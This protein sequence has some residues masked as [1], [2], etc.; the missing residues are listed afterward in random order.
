MFTIVLLITSQIGFAQFAG[1]ENYVNPEL[2]TD[3][4]ETNN[5]IWFSSKGGV[6]KI[7]KTTLQ[8]TTYDR[9]NSNL[10]INI[11][12][13][14]AKDS[15]DG[16]WIGTYNQAIAKF[17]GTTWTN[18][19]FTH[20]FAPTVI[21][22]KTYCMEIDNQDNVWV[23]TS[24]GLLRFDGT[25]WQVFNS[26][27]AG[28]MLHDV[29]ALDLDSQGNLY[30][31]SF[32]VYKYDG[33]TF[34]NLTDTTSLYLNG[35]A[36]LFFDANDNFWVSDKSGTIGKF[37][38]TTWT[39][40]SSFNGQ[41]P[42]T[43]IYT[44]GE[45]P[46]GEMYF[47]AEDSGKYILQNGVWTPQNIANNIPLDEGNLTTYF[48]D[49]QGDK[50]LANGGNLIKNDGQ[51]ITSLNLKAVE[52]QENNI[53]DVAIFNNTKYFVSSKTITTFDGTTWG[54][55]EFPDSL[56]GNSFTLRQM[57]I[58]DMNNIWIASSVKGI[59]HWNG[60]IW[61]L[62]NQNSS[63]V[64]TSYIHKIAYDAVSQILWC[65]S[66]NGLVKFDGTTWTTYDQTNSPFSGN[67]L[68]KT[69][70]V[71]Y[72]GV[73]Y[74]SAH[75]S[76]F[77]I[78]SFDGTTWQNLT[79][80][81]AGVI[82]PQSSIVSIHFDKNNT[83]W[84][85][86][87]LNGVY[88][89]DGTVWKNWNKTLW[90]LP[91]NNIM[92]ITSDDNGDIYVGTSSGAATFDGTIW[93]GWTLQNSG[94]SYKQIVDIEI[95]DNDKLW[96]GTN[97]GVSRFQLN[98][99]TTTPVITQNQALKIYPNPIIDKAIVQFTTTS[100][101]DNIQVQIISLDG[102]IIQ[103]RII[104]GNRPKGE[105]RIEIAKNNMTS[106]L[107]YLKVIWNDERGVEVILVR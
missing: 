26:Q 103:N 20:L 101:T 38:G 8:T 65:A 39:E 95:D 76:A 60:T 96:L 54:A 1:W 42:S 86:S 106:G 77:E 62:Y 92:T 23:G 68:F 35:R 32:R 75:S 2:L 94:I 56:F 24:R 43:D 4:V 6:I 69:I 46:N 104:N 98:S 48:Y 34:E 25:N 89:Y 79:V 88:K 105:Q 53:K 74:L 19:D 47:T 28:N 64:L 63:A 107:Y 3:Y 102:K 5:E 22:I 17:D 61:T 57:E 81:A 45:T 41:I 37:D 78:W 58:V 29:W 50:W 70:E 9:A 93:T 44:L 14:I 84:A 82:V 90:D 91:N 85:G 15:N 21:R 12:D 36:E 73:L 11:V 27:N 40:Y 99:T 83:L 10:S 49:N 72:N 97:H 100:A 55:F 66:Y 52:L 59:L 16:I 67:H 33:T 71:D 13:A 87:S 31:A 51:N 18:Y 30:A 80:S 7:D